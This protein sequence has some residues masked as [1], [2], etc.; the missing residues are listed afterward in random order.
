MPATP[1]EQGDIDTLNAMMGGNLDETHALALLRKHGNNLDKA[2]SALLEGD[3]GADAAQDIFADLPNLE[4]L[5]VPGVGP[6]TPPREFPL[7]FC[8]R[9]PMVGEAGW[10]K[11][12][13]SA[14]TRYIETAILTCALRQRPD[15]NKA[16]STS[17][18]R[19]MAT[20]TASTPTAARTSGRAT[21]PQTRTGKSC[22]RT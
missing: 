16:S 4:P 11:V 18:R 17:Q 12:F 2:A 13:C 14:G 1:Q 8:A 21:G 6:R 5:D 15:Q 22:R 9:E 7:F 10:G 19:S 20:P 3:T